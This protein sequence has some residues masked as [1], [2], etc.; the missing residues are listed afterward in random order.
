M[1]ALIACVLVI[2]CVA[3][4]API[5]YIRKTNQLQKTLDQIEA[6]TRKP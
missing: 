3:L 1:E 5:M 6:N 2:T 4:Y